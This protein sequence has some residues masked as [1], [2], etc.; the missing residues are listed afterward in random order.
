MEFTDWK[1]LVVED[2][3]DDLAMVSKIL[4]FHGIQVFVA[5]NGA[6]CLDV[7]PAVD[8]HL[9]MLDLSMPGMD[10]WQTLAAIRSDARFSQ[11]PVV[12]ATAY[13]AVDMDQEAHDAGFD[14]YFEKPLNPRRLVQELADI[15]GF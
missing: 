12:A 15:I 9:V 8:P 3:D 7:L 6:Q 10:G 5:R 4:N 13:Y 11:L 1:V 14:A 2:T